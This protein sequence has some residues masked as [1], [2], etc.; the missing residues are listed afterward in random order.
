[1]LAY[2]AAALL[3]GCGIMAWHA[4]KADDVAPVS[5]SIAP[6]QRE[7]IALGQRGVAVV[8][9]GAALQWEYH[10]GLSIVARQDGGRIFY[11]VDDGGPFEV[12]TAAGVVRVEGTCFRVELG[13]G[14]TPELDVTTYEGKVVFVDSRTGR[15]VSIG[16]G[17]RLS[18]GADGEHR[19]LD[20]ADAKPGAW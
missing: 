10:S 11:R 19:R 9:P 1:M 16:A 2:T 18:V 5:G 6:K 7:T 15:A 8:E 20:A 14:A 4:F 17:Q 3:V 12:H 13:H